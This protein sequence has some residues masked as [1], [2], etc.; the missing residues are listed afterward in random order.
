MTNLQKLEA[1]KRNLRQAQDHFQ[2]G[3]VAEWEVE[4]HKQAVS[5]AQLDV[6]GE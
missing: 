4:M 2:N 1:A 3:L 5:S 6:W